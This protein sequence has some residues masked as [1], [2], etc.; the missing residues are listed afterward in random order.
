MNEMTEMEKRATEA[1]EWANKIRVS[2][3]AELEAAGKYLVLLKGLMGE[4]KSTFDAPK[5][6]AHDAH[7]AVLAAEKKHLEPLEKAEAI[8]KPKV[9]AYMAAREAAERKRQEDAKLV[10]AQQ[11]E[12]DGCTEM[13]NAVLNSNVNVERP[14]VEGVSTRTVFKYRVVDSKKIPDDY[15]MLN[16][17]LIGGEVRLK[18]KSTNIP[19]IEVYEETVV[20][21][22]RGS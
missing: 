4:I 19:G 5:K 12:D 18:G 8:V 14:K 6:A 16:E 3:D 1:M 7:K 22:R 15:W 13:A 9:G 2:N 11:M 10:L 21:A 17:P 20:S